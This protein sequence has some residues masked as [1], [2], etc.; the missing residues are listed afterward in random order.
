MTRRGPDDRERSRR[1]TESNNPPA[2]ERRI[3]SAR[4]PVFIP[5]LAPDEWRPDRNPM[6]HTIG[7]VT[8][9]RS[10]QRGTLTTLII[11][12]I[13]HHRH[14]S[15]NILHRHAIVWG[16]GM[17]HRIP[18]KMTPSGTPQND[19][20]GPQSPAGENS[21]NFPGGRKSGNLHFFAPR[22]NHPSG[23]PRNPQ[24]TPK[25]PHF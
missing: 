3:T 1:V 14:S 16:S 10:A 12:V 17:T 15:L 8:P 19:P 18:P 24:N 9:E 21:G 22:K 23:P 7:D 2:A 5:D 4:V 6:H 11:E 25:T 13:D 20:P